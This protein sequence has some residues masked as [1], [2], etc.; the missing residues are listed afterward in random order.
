MGRLPVAIELSEAEEAELK[1]WRRRRTISSGLH[2]R[3]GIVLD[4]ARGYSGEVIAERR[5]TS[6]Q[7][8]TKWRRRFAESRLFEACSAFT[9]RYG[10]HARQVP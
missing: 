5:H 9:A 10:L 1:G 3:A 2:F 7:T 6:Q 8:V 4:C